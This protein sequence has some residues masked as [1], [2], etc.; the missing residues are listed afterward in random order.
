MKIYIFKEFN[1]KNKKK[2]FEYI[3]QHLPFLS[4]KS[5]G[6]MGDER[7]YKFT[8]SL[9]AVTSVDGMTA[10]SHKANKTTNRYIKIH[11]K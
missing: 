1:R 7:T 2:R 11:H 6:V 3:M 8:V 5:V 4:L 9:R 10:D